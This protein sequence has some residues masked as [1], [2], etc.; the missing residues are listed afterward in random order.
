MVMLVGVWAWRNDVQERFAE[1]KMR[2][3]KNI[4]CSSYPSVLISGAGGWK[5]AAAVFKRQVSEHGLERRISTIE[6]MHISSSLQSGR[7]RH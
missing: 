4:M 3:A 7:S 6:S 5:S 1:T 2:A